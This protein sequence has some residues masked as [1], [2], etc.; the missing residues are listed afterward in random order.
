MESLLWLFSTGQTTSRAPLVQFVRMWLWPLCLILDV[1][2]TML[3]V[4]SAGAGG[5]RSN[6]MPVWLTAVWPLVASGQSAQPT[7]QHI[8]AFGMRL[9]DT[10]NQ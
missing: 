7:C 6:L 9:P 4:G 5:Q 1:R 2:L 10:R 3:L 8:L